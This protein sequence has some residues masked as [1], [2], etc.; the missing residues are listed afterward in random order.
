MGYIVLGALFCSI[1]LCLFLCQYNADLN[2][3]YL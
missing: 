1:Y 3:I 2:N